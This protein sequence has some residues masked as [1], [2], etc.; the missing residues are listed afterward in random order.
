MSID[1]DEDN[2]ST[3]RKVYRPESGARKIIV[4]HRGGKQFIHHRD[5]PKGNVDVRYNYPARPARDSKPS[6]DR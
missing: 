2:T 6:K 5:T 3:D 1:R 4:G